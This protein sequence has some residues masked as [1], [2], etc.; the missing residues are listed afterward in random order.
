MLHSV[1]ALVE[2]L[3]ISADHP[4]FQQ[5]QSE[6]QQ[7]LEQLATVLKTLSETSDTEKISAYLRDLERSLEALEHQRQVVRS[8]VIK[9]A[10]V[11]Q[12]D[13]FLDLVNIGKI[14]ASLLTQRLQIIP[15]LVAMLRLT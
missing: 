13:D 2:L 11:V 15:N 9:Q 4:V 12:R 8:Q 5:L 6:I 7:L 10:I 3:A 14:A 1:V